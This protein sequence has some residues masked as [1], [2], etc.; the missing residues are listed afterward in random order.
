MDYN[1]HKCI[2]AR[3]LAVLFHAEPQI[4][5]T[6]SA[7]RIEGKTRFIDKSSLSSVCSLKS[8]LIARVRDIIVS[9]NNEAQE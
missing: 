7:Q 8:A 9:C 4:T 3:V 2:N 1:E 6:E 5:L